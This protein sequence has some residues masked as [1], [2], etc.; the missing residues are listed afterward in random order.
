MR[1]IFTLFCVLLMINTSYAGS[2]IWQ[3]YIILNVNG[4][5]DS[6]YAGGVNADGANAYT[7]VSLG[8]PTSLILN[9]GEVKTYKNG[10]DDVFGARLFYRVYKDGTTPGSFTEMNLPWAADLG[11]GDQKWQATSQGVD[12]MSLA[13]SNG[14]WVLEVYW[15]A[16]YNFGTHIDDN[17]GSYYSN[18]FSITTLP[19]ELSTFKATQTSN[20]IALNWTTLSEENNAGFDIEHSVNGKDFEAIG[21]VEGAGNSIE[22][23][24]YSYLDENPTVGVNY[25]RLKQT[26]FDGT[27]DYSNIIAVEFDAKIEASIFPNPTSEQLTLRTTIEDMVNIR[28][29]NING[30]VVWQ[31][32]QYIDNQLDLNINE[33]PV[34]TYW[35]QVTNESNQA[36][37]YSDIFIKE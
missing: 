13:T 31:Q 17:G 16:P 1:K 25:Y 6:Y 18:T 8:N 2:G 36:V 9:G 35:L 21:Y 23:V 34:G 30:Q 5:G 14:T 4:A 3:D 37:L 26:D 27:Y 19:V 7:S 11:G 12:I 15:T 29:V 22:Q 20:A 33:L 32:S 24:D 10:S 28:I